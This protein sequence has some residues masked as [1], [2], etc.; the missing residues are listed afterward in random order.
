MVR[1]SPALLALLSLVAGCSATPSAGD[2]GDASVADVSTVDVALDDAGDDAP[3]PVDV[4]ER[5]ANAGDGA[6]GCIEG[7]IIDAIARCIDDGM[8]PRACLARERAALGTRPLC[9][10]DRDGLADDFEDALGR[11]YALAFAYNQGDGTHTGGDPEPLWPD[12]IAHYVANSRL[13]WRVDNDSSTVREVLAHPTLT[14]LGSASIDIDGRVRYAALPDTGDG[15]NF[16]LC[17]RQVNGSYTAESQVRSMEASRTL[18]GGIDVATVVHPSGTDPGGRYAFVATVLY[19][20]YNEHS[21]VD[22]HEGDWEGGGV[23][24]D[25]ES[26]RVMAAYFDRHPSADNRRLMPLTGT[27]AVPAIDPASE[28]TFGNLCNETEAARAWGVRFWDYAG[29]RHHVVLYVSTGGHASYGYPGNTKILGV[30]CFER[31]IVRDTHNGD[32]F[33]LLP[34]L[35]VFVPG[36]TTASP[37]RVVDGVHILNLGEDRRPRL[38]WAAFHGQWGCQHNTIAKSYPGPW[39]NERHCRRWITHDWGALPP[40]ATANPSADCSGAP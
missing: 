16:W 30:G 12:N 19:Y 7:V 6:T 4:V 18:A 27:G 21:T 5:D 1:K 9:D 13:I 33:K 22:N 17:L 38:P 37:Q 20:A 26:G 15:T 31:T 40:F 3:E 34:W 14:T 32:G 11:S 10:A 29:P 36:W 24:V 2:G 25:L 35:G 28:R 8:G 39:D 23:L